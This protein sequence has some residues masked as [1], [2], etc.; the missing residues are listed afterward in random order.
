LFKHLQPAGIEIVT[1]DISL[2]GIA[3]FPEYLTE[4][5]VKDSLTE[6]GKLATNNIIKYKYPY[7]LP[8]LK[9]L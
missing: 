5:R 6:L 1:E 3:N 8:Q 2:A 9:L 4:Q 7:Q